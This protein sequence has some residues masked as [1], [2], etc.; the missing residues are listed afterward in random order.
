M[1][2][3]YTVSMRSKEPMLPALVFLGRNFGDIPVNEIDSV[4]GF[5]ERSSLYGG[6]EFTQSEIVDRD[7]KQLNAVGIGIRLPMSNHHVTREEFEE[8]RDLFEKYH[9]KGNSV[10]VTHDDLAR[11]VRDE[12]PDYQ[13]EASVIKN[14]NTVTK[15]EAAFDLYDT[16]V[17]PMSANRDTQMLQE[18]PEKQRVTLFGNAGCALTCPSKICY[19]SVSKLNKFT[20]D[21]KF[22]CSQSLKSREM[23]GMID[24]DLEA[25]QELGF[26]RF[27]MLRSRPGETTGF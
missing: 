14:I 4:F 6:R 10:I 12:F 7:V 8:N 11:W 19:P 3:V 26:R 25:L 5:V 15:V 2:I 27:K 13:I 23:E 21:A 20:G 9:I 16:V 22:Q 1:S 18:V 17:L 24:F